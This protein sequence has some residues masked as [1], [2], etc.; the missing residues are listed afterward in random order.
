MTGGGV[1]DLAQN[2]GQVALSCEDGD[3]TYWVP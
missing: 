3:G 2:E 1:T